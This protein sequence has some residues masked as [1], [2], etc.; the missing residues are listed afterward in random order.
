[1]PVNLSVC[2]SVFLELLV[3]LCVC[4]SFSLS[5]HRR[6]GH[7]QEGHV[8]VGY[9][10]PVYGF[11]NRNLCTAGS[12]IGL[13]PDITGMSETEIAEARKVQYEDIYRQHMIE[14]A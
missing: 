8:L 6:L 14:F 9:K 10:P 12:Y 5:S 1:M 4:I 11:Q 7:D 3:W 2:P 13:Y